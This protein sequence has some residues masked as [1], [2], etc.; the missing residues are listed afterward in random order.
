MSSDVEFCSKIHLVAS[1]H[2]QACSFKQDLL[3]PSIAIR[4]QSLRHDRE[5][6]TLDPKIGVIIWT[7]GVLYAVYPVVVAEDGAGVMALITNNLVDVWMVGT[8]CIHAE[9]VE[10]NVKLRDRHLVSR[11]AFRA[12]TKMQCCVVRMARV[13]ILHAHMG[14]EDVVVA[15]VCP[16]G[17]S[18]HEG[19]AVQNPKSA[20]VNLPRSGLGG[21]RMGGDVLTGSWIGG[22]R[23]TDSCAG[24]NSLRGSQ[25]GRV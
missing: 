16:A 15:Q 25:V 10:S 6:I 4:P 8:I 17:I 20:G 1:Y 21:G 13:E 14:L 2:T 12:G 18:R 19:S 5:V 7:V 9:R 11:V 24:G 3:L 22:S 23:E